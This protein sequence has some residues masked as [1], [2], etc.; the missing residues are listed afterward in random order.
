[1]RASIAHLPEI[2]YPI[3]FLAV[4]AAQLCVPIPAILFLAAAGTLAALGKMNLLLII[5]GAT[6]GCLIGDYVWF[7]AGRRIGTRALRIFG[8]F[9]SDRRSLV[10]N[11]KQAF[12]R[13][14]VYLFLIAK[15]VPG[16]DGML[17]PLAGTQQQPLLAFF[18]FDAAGSALWAAFY[19]GIGYLFA[20]RIEVI[21]EVLGRLTTYFVWA[22]IVPVGVYLSWRLIRLVRMVLQLRMRSVS[23]SQLYEK[24]KRQVRVMVLDLN[25]FDS[26]EEAT[27]WVGIPGAVC[28]DPARLRKSQVVSSIPD[29]LQIILYS[30]SGSELTT[31]RAALSLQARGVTRVWILRGGLKSWRE[32]GLPVS[33]QV[34][35]VVDL[36]AR[37]GIRIA[38]LT[39]HPTLFHE[40]T[41]TP[42]QR[43][44]AVSIRRA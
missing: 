5:T 20:Y 26:D 32:L 15:F 30:S 13:W 40:T 14:G 12:N 25:L 44:Q 11:T 38:D 34:I 21:V 23:P 1:M 36:A 42:A 8:L 9:S 4:L 37:Y 24:L 27:D 31:A 29:D 2:T 7:V 17:P 33:T 16:L 6:V 10:K 19:S 3:V 22:I 41:R 18:L 43:S 39:G 28:I 35:E